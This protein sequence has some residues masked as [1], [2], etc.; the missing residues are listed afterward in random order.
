[1]VIQSNVRT[2]EHWAVVLLFTSLFAIRYK[3]RTDLEE[4]DIELAICVELKLRKV[5]Y[6]VV[7]VYRAPNFPYAVILDYLDDLT[8]KSLRERKQIIILGDL[9]AD[10]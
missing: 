6:L 9:N 5:T 10:Y 4:A 8:H 3:R 7:C 1:M 2:G